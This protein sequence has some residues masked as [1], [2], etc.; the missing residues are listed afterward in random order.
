ML[1]SLGRDT[2]HK[3]SPSP[4]CLVCHTRHHTLHTMIIR[5]YDPLHTMIIRCDVAQHIG[6]LTRLAPRPF[7]QATYVVEDGALPPQQ[8]STSAMDTSSSKRVAKAA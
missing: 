3:T 7:A 5:C 1:Y 6:P 2:A 4:A 8:R